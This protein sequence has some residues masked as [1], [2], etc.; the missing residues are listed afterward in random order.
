MKQQ[1]IE[2]IMETYN[3]NYKQ[4]EARYNKMTY[5]Q[6]LE[7]IREVELEACAWN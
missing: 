1:I 2:I 3:Y 6:R 4:A 7:F 5:S